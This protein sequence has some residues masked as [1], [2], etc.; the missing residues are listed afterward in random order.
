MP[1]IG[2][3]V[4]WHRI[5]AVGSGTHSLASF[6]ASGTLWP[7]ARLD[8]IAEDSV[9]PVPCVLVVSICSRSSTHCRA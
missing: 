9:Q 2:R 4:K 1:R 8:A 7:S 3:L 5:S 6:T